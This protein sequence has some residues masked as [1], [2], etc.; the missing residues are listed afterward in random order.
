MVT[1]F[2]EWALI[3]D[4]LGKGKQNL[5]LRKGG[6]SE[7]GGEFSLKSQKFVLFPTHFHQGTDLIKESWR[8][9]LSGD[10]YKVDEFHVKLEYFAQVVDSKII[11]DLKLLQKLNNYHAWKEEVIQEKFERWDKSVFMMV[12][13]VFKLIEPVTILVKPEYSGC[14]SWIELEEEIDLSGHPVLNPGIH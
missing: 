6:I 3:V 5:I 13:Q 10:Q 14:K 9:F 8:P 11:T 4:A 7:E 12:V 2:K 1:A